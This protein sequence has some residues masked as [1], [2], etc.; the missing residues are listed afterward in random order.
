MKNSRHQPGDRVEP[1]L[2]RRVNA[3]HVLDALFE[4][5]PRTR[6][7]LRDHTGISAP[8]MSKLID[9]LIGRGLVEEEPEPLLTMGRPSKVFRLARTTARILGAVIDIGETRVF[10]CGLDG[11]I[12]DALVRVFPTPPTYGRLL[13]G[14]AREAGR[15][16]LENRAPCLGLGVTVP[17]LFNA[18]EGRVM[19]SPNLRFLDGTRL[20][21]DLEERLRLKTILFQEE[22]TLK[23]SLAACPIVRSRGSKKQGAAAAVISTL[24]RTA[25]PSIQA[26]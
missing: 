24:F 2:L 23:P 14:V 22:H 26:S 10:S 8:T 3:R 7:A 25:G 11:G 19:L 5:G 20:G 15:L 4:L 17:G 9:H 6:T 21:A 18:R 16:A 1:A 12:D 13:S